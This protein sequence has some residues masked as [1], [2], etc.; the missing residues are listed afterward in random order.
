MP[1]N[2]ITMPNFFRYFYTL[3]PEY[4][5]RHRFQSVVYTTIKMSCLK[6]R[7]VAHAFHCFYC[8]TIVSRTYSYFI[9]TYIHIHNP[10]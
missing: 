3:T 5:P 7:T 6:F 8:L 4:A 10:V 2:S 1:T 9:H